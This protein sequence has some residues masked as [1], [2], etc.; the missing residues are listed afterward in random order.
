MGIFDIFNKLD[1]KSNNGLNLIHNKITKD[2]LYAFHKKN[3]EI[4]GLFQVF[5]SVSE[6]GNNPNY[7]RKNVGFVHQE[8]FF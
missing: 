7:K 6:S 2:L 8:Y 3:G 4:E 5:H 1:T